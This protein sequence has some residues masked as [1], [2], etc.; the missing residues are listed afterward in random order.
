MEIFKAINPLRILQVYI[1]RD[2]LSKEDVSG[3][4]VV[5]FVGRPRACGDGRQRGKMASYYIQY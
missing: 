3:L 5:K 1:K 4:W 2:S